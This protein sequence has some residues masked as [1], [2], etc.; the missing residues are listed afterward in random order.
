MKIGI[1]THHYVK[2]FGAYMQ[3]YA[4]MNTIKNMYPNINIEIIDYRVKKHEMN[5]MIHFFGF[6]PKRGDTICGLFRKI[7]LFFTHK[8]SEGKLP[9][10]K[11]LKNVS[12][13]NEQGYDLIIVGS[14][15]VW[16]F[17]DIAYTPIKFGE[18]I[19][20]PMITYSASAGGSSINDEVPKCVID[21]IK[22]FMNIA[23]RD[24]NTAELVKKLSDREP[25]RTLDP[26]YLYDYNL[27]FR[28]K[29][30]K[31]IMEKPYI[32]IYDC[33]LSES[34]AQKI[35]EFAEEHNMNIIGAGE[36]RNWYSTIETTDIT[37]FEWAYLFKNAWGVVTGT[38]HGTS[39]AIKYNRRFAA[40]LT[41]PNRI[42]KVSSLL[43]EFNLTNQIVSKD[44]EDKF[45]EILENQIDYNN[46][47]KI[48]DE[49]VKKSKDYLKEEISKIESNIK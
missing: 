8:K 38:F 33:S 11:K 1:L 47:N 31:I 15:E 25:V 24:E 4:L 49:K 12:D 43:K 41:A 6:K 46:V 44:N 40:Y 9:R 16:N 26:V 21:G 3:V 42:K 28:N 22:K 34:K 7:G 30:E 29:I 2:N 14:D 5:N 18:G 10:S 35:K 39:F 37:P 19:N 27:T 32:L 13:I 45:L 36:Y 48:I 20:V 23:V 17:N